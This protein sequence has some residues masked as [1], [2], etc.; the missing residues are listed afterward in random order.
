MT[1]TSWR[2]ADFRVED[3]AMPYDPEGEPLGNY[4]FADYPNG[5]LRTT[6]KD[7]SRFLRM[8]VLDGTLDGRVLLKPA[9]VR[10]MKRIQYPDV[11]GA[12]QQGL[13]WTGYE[14]GSR[15][16]FGHAG[17]EAGASTAMAYDPATNTGTILFTNGSFL[18]EEDE[19][20]FRG[21]FLSL[22]QEGDKR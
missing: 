7:L 14:V 21:L 11:A 8:F 3:M 9:N 1:R 17:A 6:V 13:G 12:E 22:V 16:F 5:A 2:V 20:A 4:T 15:N 18:H 10:E 19:N